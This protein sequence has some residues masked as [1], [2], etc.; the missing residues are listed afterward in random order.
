MPWA[1][2][3]RRLPPGADVAETW[4]RRT[5]G[6]KVRLVEI[7]RAVWGGAL[8]IGPRFVLARVFRVR[9]DRRAV[10]VARVLGG[11]QLSQAVLSGVA[12]SPEV[13]AIGVWVDSV[14][15]VTALGLAAADRDRLRPGLADAAVAL[16]WS[17]L[18]CRDLQHAHAANIDLDRWR[19]RLA[20]KAM[21]LLPFAAWLQAAAAKSRSTGPARPAH[22]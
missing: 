7:V 21:D 18:G 9:V 17:W 8:L 16:C 10:V 6:S 15:A 2:Q 20:R 22:T 3:A 13:L 4:T 5:T 14:H 11:R 12:P 1:P 19:D